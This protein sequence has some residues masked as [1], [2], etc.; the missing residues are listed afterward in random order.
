VICEELGYVVRKEREIEMDGPC[1]FAEVFCA[2]E[3]PSFL[4]ICRSRVFFCCCWSWGGRVAETGY[5][6]R[7][8]TASGSL[9]VTA[10]TAA[11]VVA[12][13]TR[14]CC[15]CGSDAEDV[16]Y[17]VWTDVPPGFGRTTDT[18]VVCDAEKLTR[19][20]AVEES[21]AGRRWIGGREEWE[22]VDGE[23]GR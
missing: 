6:E 9:S 10:V 14:C 4:V 17:G 12:A 23:E 1:P 18:G 11:T 20:K 8:E 19:C 13:R 22:E 21:F 2:S 7:C 16:V 15:C 3:C 5:E